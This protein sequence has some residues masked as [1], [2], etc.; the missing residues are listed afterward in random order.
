MDVEGMG[1]ISLKMCDQCVSMANCHMD[2]ELEA[3][4]A[5]NGQSSIA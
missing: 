5:G 4:R 2:L 1:V 3:F